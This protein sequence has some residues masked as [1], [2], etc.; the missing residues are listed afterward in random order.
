MILN[1]LY[2]LLFFI[3]AKKR[4]DIAAYE[5]T[6]GDDADSKDNKSFS[7]E[8]MKM[9]FAKV[10]VFIGNLTA[11]YWLEYIITTGWSDRAWRKGV[12]FDEDNFFDANAYV[13]LATTYQIGVFISRTSVQFFRFPWVTVLTLFQVVNFILFAFVAFY[14]GEQFMPI[15][16]QIIVMLWTGLMGGCSYSNCMY[17]VLNSDKLDKKEKEVT[18][19][20]GSMCYDTGIFLAGISALIISNFVIKTEK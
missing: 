17:Y 20:I 5:G 18:I 2:V 1:V 15:W 19:N 12:E 4:K 14:P 3:L 10:G 7:W 8:A 16:G 13:V 9:S 6:P 11:V